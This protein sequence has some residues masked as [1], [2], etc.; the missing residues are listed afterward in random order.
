MCYF[1]IKYP[2]CS[3]WLMTKH[4][5]TRGIKND[6]LLI[7]YQE[8]LP[9]KQRHK[10]VRGAFLKENS[11]QPIP[12]QVEEELITISV[13]WVSAL[14]QNSVWLW[15]DM[16]HILLFK[17][18][19]AESLDQFTRWNCSKCLCWSTSKK[20]SRIKDRR[21][22]K[23]LHWGLGHIWSSSMC[24]SIILSR[25]DKSSIQVILSTHLLS[26]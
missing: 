6:L 5:L 13:P 23:C 11:S 14:S 24:L 3:T 17:K 20:F 1:P 12:Y 22:S 15:L 18:R 9:N 16:P 25:G 26:V 21:K 4:R 10:A 8:P 2:D 19:T 7:F